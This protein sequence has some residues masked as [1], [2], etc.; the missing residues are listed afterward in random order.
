MYKAVLFDLDGTLTDSGEGITRC[1]AY[2]LEKLGRPQEDLEKLR[3][4]VGP[5]LKDMF[6]SFAGLTEEEALEAIRYYRERFVPIG[7][8]ENSVYPG[9]EEVLSTLQKKGY[10]LA[11]ASSKPETFVHTVLSYFSIEDY[12]EVIVGAELD[13]RRATKEEAIEEAIRRLDMEGK[14]DQILMVG[15]TVYDVQGAKALGMDVLAVSY[16]YGER[17][18]LIQS[19]PTALA[20]SPDGILDFFA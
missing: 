6:M 8:Y 10:R 9:I 13:G 2:A 5:P 17:E 11:I 7:I 16:G 15:D 3:V 1:V 18:D 12:F 14:V 20:D 19:G 4:F